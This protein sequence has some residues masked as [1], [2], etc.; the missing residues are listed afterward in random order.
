MRF[1]KADMKVQLQLHLEPELKTVSHA[2]STG[3][4]RPAPTNSSIIK[5]CLITHSVIITSPVIFSLKIHPPLNYIPVH[6]LLFRFLTSLVPSNST[7]PRIL[8]C[9]LVL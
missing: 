1:V 6:V 2:S 3:V 7:I 8:A 4:M 9:D 5:V